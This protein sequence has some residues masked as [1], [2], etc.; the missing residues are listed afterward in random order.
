MRCGHFYH[1]ATMQRLVG[2]LFAGASA[3][4]VLAVLATVS[5]I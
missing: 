2:N 1:S 4:Q 3:F 5:Q